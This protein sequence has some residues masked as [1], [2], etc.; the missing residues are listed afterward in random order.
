MMAE[1]MLKPQMRAKRMEELVSFIAENAEELELDV[2]D[3]KIY[4]SAKRKNFYNMKVQE[5]SSKREKQE[6]VVDMV[7]SAHRA[8]YSSPIMARMK[9][10]L[11]Y[12][13]EKIKFQKMEERA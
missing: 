10:R 13:P 9:L 7:A 5:S 4:L 8:G 11:G 6:I 3:S 2:S 1:D 12:V